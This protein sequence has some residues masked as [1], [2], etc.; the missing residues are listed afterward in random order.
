MEIIKSGYNLVIT[1]NPGI[2]KS[3]FLFFFMH[4]LCVKEQDPTVI[5]YRHLEK[6]WYLF[7][8]DKVLTADDTDLPVV[9]WIRKLL[10]N[11][12]TWYLVDTAEPLQ[13]KAKTLLVSSPYVERYKEFRKTR[14]MI[15]FMPIWSKK[16]LDIARKAMIFLVSCHR[17]C[18]LTL[19]ICRSFIIAMYHKIKWMIC[20]IGGGVFR[21]MYLRRQIS[22]RIRMSWMRQ[23][24]NVK[25][26]ILVLTQVLK[27]PLSTYL[28]NYCT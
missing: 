21:V 6:R 9:S 10:D 25:P 28:T 18:S 24:A 1:G 5:L 13:V 17:S 4:F 15:R 27:E 3:Y 23:S 22:R 8:K 11:P 14:A 20:M 12:N 2:G 7:S 26:P 16:E 19:F